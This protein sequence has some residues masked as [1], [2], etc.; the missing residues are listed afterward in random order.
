M[1]KILALTSALLFFT[2][3]SVKA[4]TGLAFGITG[5]MHYL[6]ADGDEIARDS[7]EVNSGSH[8][9]T[10][11]IPEIFLETVSDSFT[12]GFAY[13][14]TRELGSKSRTD[15]D[16]DDA[17]ENDDGVYKASAEFENVMQIYTD[18]KPD[19]SIGN[20]PIHYKVGVQRATI[21]SL[22]SLNSGSVYPEKELFGWTLGVGTMGDLPIGNNLF[23]KAEVT[24]TDFEGLESISDAGNKV[25]ADLTDMAAKLSV[26]IRF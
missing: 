19:F 2:F 20:F 16:G 21:K 9:E 13:I 18:I 4:E 6:E 25:E 1:K 15:A 11:Y 17:A 8:D 26:G 12:I 7:A 23:Y 5:A 14:P 3:T 24:Y 10:V 22:S